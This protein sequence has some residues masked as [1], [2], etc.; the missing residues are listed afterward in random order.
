MTWA[1]D[2]F[3]V[4]ACFCYANTTVGTVGRVASH[5]RCD[6]KNVCSSGS[7]EVPDLEKVGLLGSLQ[8]SAAG[9]PF[10]LFFKHR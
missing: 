4:F 1:F 9:F 6:S 5:E 8:G 2:I 10:F 7:A 3:G